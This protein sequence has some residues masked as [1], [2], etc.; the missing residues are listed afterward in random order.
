MLFSD[1]IHTKEEIQ[2]A[3][4]LINLNP[5]NV[6]IDNPKPKRKPKPKPKSKR[7][8]RQIQYV[9]RSTR[10]YKKRRRCNN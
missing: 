3:E 2:A 4:A 5:E 1:I 6:I 7:K 8:S 9:R 10:L